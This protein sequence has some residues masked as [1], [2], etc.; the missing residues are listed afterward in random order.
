MV[1]NLRGEG[2]DL[3]CVW[4]LPAFRHIVV[5]VKRRYMP[6]WEI[7]ADPK[8]YVGT[9][10]NFKGLQLLGPS[11]AYVVFLSIHPSVVK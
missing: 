9:Q 6:L 7:H 4:E 5:E 1:L 3:M 2:P 10:R 8:V 11:V